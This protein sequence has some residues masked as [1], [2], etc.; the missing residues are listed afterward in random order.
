M[1]DLVF[2]IVARELVMLSGDFTTTSNPSVQNGGIIEESRCAFISN[3]MLGIGLE[4]IINANAG[5]AAYEMNRWQSQCKS[6][7]ATLAKWNAT[8]T[9]TTAQL[10]TFI[11]Y[12]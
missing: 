6:D 10:N 9:G 5:K 4:D 8:Y 3:P 12:E 2:D 7:G 11:S 1:N